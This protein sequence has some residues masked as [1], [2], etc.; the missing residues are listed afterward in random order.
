MAAPVVDPSLAARLSRLDTLLAAQ[1]QFPGLVAAVV[2]RGGIV[3]SKAYGVRD[4]STHAPVELATEFRIGSITKVFTA[5]AVLQ[6][7]D[8]GKV[9]LDAPVATWIPELATVVGVTT[10]SPPITARHLMTHR[11]GLPR[12]PQLPDPYGMHHEVTE[13]ELLASLH[14]T[15][16]ESATGT[17]ESY[18]NLGAALEG[19]IV[20]RVS[21]EPYADYMQA[22][23]LGPL[24][25]TTATFD[26]TKVASLA[27]SYLR[28]RDGVLAPAVQLR[29]GATMARGQL[30]ASVGDLAR[31]A[32]FE[33]TA[34]PPRDDADA[35]PVRRSTI[36]ESQRTEGPSQ[37][38]DHTKGAGWF[39][40]VTPKGV[41]VEHGGSGEGFTS[42]LWFSTSANLA[43]IVMVNVEDSSLMKV[44]H[45]AQD[46]LLPVPVSGLELVARL[47]N[48]P[49]AAE[50]LVAPSYL[51]GMRKR[52]TLAAFASLHDC[53][54][55]D[56]A[57]QCGELTFDVKVTTDADRITSLRLDARH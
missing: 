22:H 11:S 17:E 24:G 26:R 3:W 40:D 41:V 18:S 56:T 10:D 42:D 16:L 44:A 6:L 43:F 35:G 15:H 50:R 14:T 27:S 48:D 55:V 49:S 29:E 1:H 33:L 19:L 31:L 53:K 52:G 12:E 30:Y 47:I 38:G 4:V 46:I 5:L 7:R 8:Q 28:S 34:W 13:A 21:G 23:L 9:D 54:V 45:D 32:T 25:M 20:A 39:L 57:I 36:R 2:G 51:V 37:P